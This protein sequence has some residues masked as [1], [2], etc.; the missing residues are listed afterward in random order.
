MPRVKVPASSMSTR[1]ETDRNKSGWVIQRRAHGSWIGAK[2]DCL[3]HALIPIVPVAERQES[4]ERFKWAHF[5][6]QATEDALWR[7]RYQIVAAQR[8]TE[9]AEQAGRRPPHPTGS[10]LIDVTFG[11]AAPASSPVAAKAS[12]DA[13]ETLAA[14]RQ[15]V[16]AADQ[17]SALARLELQ[18]RNELI[19]LTEFKYGVGV[20]AYLAAAVVFPLCVLTS[21]PRTLSVLSTIV[22]PASLALGVVLL[23]A[24]FISL[25][26]TT[27]RP[28]VSLVSPKQMIKETDVT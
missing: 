28:S 14:W 26:R 15:A 3:T 20:L 11:D 22:V 5:R 17:T 23:I 25:S 4:W 6:I 21:G 10:P 2:P 9:A 8:Q 7:A 1:A 12:A 24:F 27:S 18:R 13:H 19:P 16:H